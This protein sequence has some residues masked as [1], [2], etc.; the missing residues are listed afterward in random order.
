MPIFSNNRDIRE[1]LKKQAPDQQA[2][3]CSLGTSATAPNHAE[4]ASPPPEDA[5]EV[6]T[7]RASFLTQ[8]WR[9]SLERIQ[10]LESQLAEAHAE[11]KRLRDTP[12][13]NLKRS[14]DIVRAE[15]ESLEREVN[16]LQQ[17]VH[18]L[19]EH[20]DHIYKSYSWRITSPLRKLWNV[21]LAMKRRLQR[22]K[23]SGL[24]LVNP[25]RQDTP[26]GEMSPRSKIIL[27][28]IE[29]A[30]MYSARAAPK[31]NSNLHV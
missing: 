25:T 22:N 30:K 12:E 28:Y 5:L 16:Y 9:E 13:W 3:R 7:D 26:V 14:L 4:N 31:G 10:C 20:I 29:T 19:N 11:I 24:S 23:P 21:V 15:K 27:H 2:Q 1:H 6:D 17:R 18:E 8:R